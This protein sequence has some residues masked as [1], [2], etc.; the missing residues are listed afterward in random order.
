MTPTDGYQVNN[1]R[2]GKDY[3]FLLEDME[4]AMTKDQLKRVTKK[5]NE[6]YW[7][8]IIAEMEKR[9]PVEILIALIHQAKKGRKIRPLRIDW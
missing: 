7:I 9:N 4:F 8:P 1:I 6:G 2:P 3:V 5:W